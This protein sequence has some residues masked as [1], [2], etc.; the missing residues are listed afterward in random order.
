MEVCCSDILSREPSARRI[1][2]IYL[3]DAANLHLQQHSYWGHDL[4]GLILDRVEY[5]R[6]TRAMPILFDIR[7][8]QW[9][10]PALGLLIYPSK[11][12]SNLPWVWGS[13]TCPL[14]LAFSFY[15]HHSSEGNSHTVLLILHK[16]FP[17]E[18]L[19][20]LILSWCRLLEDSNL[21]IWYTEWGLAM[22]SI[23]T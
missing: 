22:S 17:S 20:G 1:A 18:S 6:D 8:L 16:H 13:P 2:G 10:I 4:L 5:S 15:L 14:I 21:Y 19:A 12:F 3:P 9:E 7:H 11:T 23:T